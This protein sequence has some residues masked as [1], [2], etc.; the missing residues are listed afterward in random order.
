MPTN[1]VHHHIK[2][3]LD[4][5]I[6]PGTAGTLE[7]FICPPAVRDDPRPAIYIWSAR[8]SERRQSL[9]RAAAPYQPVGQSGWKELTHTIEATLTWFDDNTDLNVDH[10]FPAVVDCVLQALRSAADPVYY[11]TDPLTGQQSELYAIGEKLTYD[12]AP[13]RAV[14]DQRYLRFDASFIITIMEAFQA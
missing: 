2:G 10:A 1:T 3:I 8:G 13:P 9:P 4:G 11:V 12:M 7:A 6:V 14:A 5:L